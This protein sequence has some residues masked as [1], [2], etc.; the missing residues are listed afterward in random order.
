MSVE[1]SLLGLWKNFNCLKYFSSISIQ[2]LFCTFQK[3]PTM[4]SAVL[5]TFLF[6]LQSCFIIRVYAP[7]EINTTV[8]T[9]SPSSQ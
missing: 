1:E 8:T 3:K 2:M 6:S 9:T 5:L 7:A 4:R